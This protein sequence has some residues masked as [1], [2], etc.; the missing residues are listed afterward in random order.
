MSTQRRIHLTLPICGVSFQH[1]TRGKEEH[2]QNFGMYRLS[3]FE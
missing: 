2:R 1:C 3:Q